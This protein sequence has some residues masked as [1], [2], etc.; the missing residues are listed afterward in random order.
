MRHPYRFIFLFIISNNTCNNISDPFPVP[1]AL[2]TTSLRIPS[3][4]RTYNE[5]KGYSTITADGIIG[6]G[7]I[8]ALIIALQIEEG[9]SNPDG[10]F[11]KNTAVNCPELSKGY[12]DVT[13]HFCKL[14]QHALYCKGYDPGSVKGTFGSAT[15]TAIQNIQ[16]DAGIPQT[17]KVNGKLM[18]Q[19]L[20]LDALVNR[21]DKKIREIQLALNGNYLDYFDIIP[22][23]GLEDGK[24]AVEAALEL[25]FTMQTN[26]E[27]ILWASTV[28][29]T[30][31][32][33][34]VTPDMHPPAL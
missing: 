19:I 24:E 21:G 12:I 9:D 18:K 7:T 3:C 1:S 27:T 33:R 10:I 22:T 2:N 15:E 4:K 30:H 20:S 8:K 28:P 16:R 25:G 14:L 26:A 23:D 5:K 6:A 17:G 31:A 29:E 13:H 32:F 11:G 34:F